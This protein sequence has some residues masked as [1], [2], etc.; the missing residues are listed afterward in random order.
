MIAEKWRTVDGINL[1]PD[2]VKLVQVTDAISGGM[3]LPRWGWPVPG[4]YNGATGAERIWGWQMTWVAN[5]TG[6]LP[7]P[8]RCSVCTKTT[9]LG[10]HAELYGR[11]LLV[12]AVCRSCHFHIHR[13]FKASAPWQAYVAKWSHIDWITRLPVTELSREAASAL[14]TEFD[15]FGL[16]TD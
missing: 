1:A 8:E 11:P 12:K 16:T 14:E 15:P 2:I 4:P 3:R 5:R 6:L 13:R 7:W 10:L 9:N